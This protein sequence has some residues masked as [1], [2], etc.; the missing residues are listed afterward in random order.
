M[1][2]GINKLITK[3]GRKKLLIIIALFSVLILLSIGTTNLIRYNIEKKEASELTEI[4]YEFK[5][6]NENNKKQAY[7]LVKFAK[8]E[9]IK[10][11]TDFNGLTIYPN[12][13]MIVSIDYTLTDRTNY[14]FNVEYMTGEKKELDLY[15]ELPRV[16]GVYVKKH[17]AYVNA[18]D[19]SKGF[20]PLTTRYMYMNEDGNMVPGDWLN[21]DEP[22]YW[23][24]YNESYWANIFVESEGVE[25]YYMWIPRYCYKKDEEN[26]ID[27]NERVDIKFI[28]V[29][30]EYI[31]AQTDEKIEWPELEAQGYVIPEAF[32][33]D[34]VLIPGYWIS[35]YQLS[36]KSGF[37][38]SFEAV[39]DLTSIHVTTY[40]P[41]LENVKYTYAIDGDIKATTTNTSYTFTNVPEGNKVINVTAIDEDGKIVASMTKTFEIIEP[42]KPDLTG[43]DPYTT[44]YAYWDDNGVEHSEIPISKDPPAEWYNYTL[45]KWANIVVR[46]E[47]TESYFMWIPRYEYYINNELAALQAPNER[48]TVRFLDGTTTDTTPGYL[49]PEAFTWE[50]D[51]GNIVQLTGYWMSKYQL[52]EKQSIPRVMTEMGVGANVVRIGSITGTNITANEGDLSIEYY[53]DGVRK[54]T[55][56]NPE[57]KYSF[58][59]LDANSTYG[60]TVMVRKASTGEMLGAV[61][62]RV[63]TIEANKPDLTGFNEEKT[64]YVVGYRNDGTPIIG[65]HILND[66]SNSPDN[67][68]DYSNRTWANIVITDGTVS[69]GE[70]INYTYIS[71][72]MWIP[73]YQYSLDE[74]TQRVNIKFLPGKSVDKLNG[75][76]IPESFTWGDGEETVQLTG[77]WISKYQLS[78]PVK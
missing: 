20:D 54:H 3:Y 53:V 46:N 45:R 23:Y 67:W 71:Y 25:S 56:N 73:R 6:L 10:E 65:D 52:S 29:Y 26:S 50:D 33:W 74:T 21:G 48:V 58:T 40:A 32:T 41:N 55:G 64:Y 47:G 59:G 4:S 43:F 28:N 36:D 63:E 7:V 11:I 70:I 17:D 35:K 13:K 61:S 1:I 37:D 44:F 51:D 60:I 76:E 78:E 31:D 68:Y 77:Y 27:G 2:K 30:D 15:F 62:Q 8:E 57:E 24:D 5:K 66:G 39:V 49:I 14:K 72:F 19:V 69:N 22:D 38:L 75:Y 18:P 42:N 16:P 34:Y 9:G 12:G